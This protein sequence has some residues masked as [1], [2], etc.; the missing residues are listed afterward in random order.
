MSHSISAMELRQLEL[1]KERQL[2]RYVA[3]PKVPS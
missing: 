3:K 2:K 1:E